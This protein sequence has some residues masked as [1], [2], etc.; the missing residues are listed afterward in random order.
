RRQ[1]A[2]VAVGRLDEYLSLFE[3]SR[4]ALA[5]LQRG[6]EFNFCDGEVAVERETLPVEAG[7]SERK[8]EGRGAA[9]RHDAY[10][11][12]VRESHQ[13]CARVG[14]SREACFGQES[15]VAAREERFEECRNIARP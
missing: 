5:F 4:L 9:P 8:H 6:D 14:Y 1:S 2:I 3:L 7:S 15:R 10:V 13:A 11:A 12:L